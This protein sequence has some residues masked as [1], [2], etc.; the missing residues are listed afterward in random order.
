MSL[1]FTTSTSLLVQGK[2]FPIKEH[3]KALGGVWK[4]PYWVLPLNADTP[5]NRSTLIETLKETLKN[6]IRAEKELRRSLRLAEEE[7]KNS[8][9]GAAAAEQQYKTFLAEYRKQPESHWICCDQCRVID[10]ARQ[11]T[12][13]EACAVDGNSFRVRG[14]IRT[15][16]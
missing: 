6:T 7:Y 14:S 4:A 10:W 15:G 9:E 3:L 2:T 13:C 11:H 16:D 8:V 1:L 12:V 5:T